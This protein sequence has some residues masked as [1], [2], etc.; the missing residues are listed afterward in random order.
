MQALKGAVSDLYR[1][2]DFYS[3]KIGE[4]FFSEVFKVGFIF[5]YHSLPVPCTL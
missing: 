2:D 3:E 4:G 1:L 5:G